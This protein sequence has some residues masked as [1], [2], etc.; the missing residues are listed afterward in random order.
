MADWNPNDWSKTGSI[1]GGAAGSFGGP[2]GT[3]VGSAAGAFLPQLLHMLSGS[4]NTGGQQGKNITG[5]D[6]NQNPDIQNIRKLW[7]SSPYNQPFNPQ[8]ANQQFN[9]Q[10]AD[11]ATK[12]YQERIQ[13]NTR[14]QFFQPSGVSGTAMQKAL[15]QGAEDLGGSLGSLRSNYLQGQ[16]ENHAKG[17]YNQIAQRLGLV[18]NQANENYFDPNAQEGGIGSEISGWLG[19]L[20]SNPQ[21]M[22]AIKQKFGRNGQ[23]IVGEYTPWEIP[24]QLGG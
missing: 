5:Y 3:A 1:A 14:N 17:Q 16:Q 9:E 6:Y 18:N 2:I 23:D 24:G 4:T 11:P 12:Y 7:E 19:Q 8:Q 13:P 20:L 15:T 21:F 10:V 22:Q